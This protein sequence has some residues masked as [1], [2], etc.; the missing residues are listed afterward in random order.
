MHSQHGWISKVLHMLLAVCTQ[1]CSPTPVT[2]R[3]PPIRFPNPYHRLRLRPTRKI[4]SPL[5]LHLVLCTSSLSRTACSCK[6]QQQISHELIR[7][8]AWLATSSWCGPIL[9]C[10]RRVVALE[11]QPTTDSTPGIP[12]YCR[13]ATS[14]NSITD[15]RRRHRLCARISAT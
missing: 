12:L 10:R 9:P 13:L 4:P 1:A 5:F 8:T 15:G 14:S 11:R 2:E 3:V 7:A 6:A